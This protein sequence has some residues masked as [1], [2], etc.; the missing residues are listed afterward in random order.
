MGT[1]LEKIVRVGMYFLARTPS[2]IHV[3]VRRTE[4]IRYRTQPWVL[5]SPLEPLK[6]ICDDDFETRRSG[7]R[8]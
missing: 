1:K 2:Y 7:P 8:S 3:Y 6:E 4:Y 5:F